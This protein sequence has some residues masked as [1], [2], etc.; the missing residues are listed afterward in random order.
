MN[1]DKTSYASQYAEKFAEFNESS[2]FTDLAN[3]STA[4]VGTTTADLISNAYRNVN[5]LSL[6]AIYIIFINSTCI[7][8]IFITWILL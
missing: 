7:C 5:L 6:L 1:L 2:S 8:S 4:P 3:M